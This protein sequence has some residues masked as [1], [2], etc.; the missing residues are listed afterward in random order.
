MRGQLLAQGLSLLLFSSLMLGAC[1]MLVNEMVAREE[2]TIDDGS[3]NE[4]QGVP[5]EGWSIQLRPVK[6]SYQVGENVDFIFGL[7]NN[8]GRVLSV[9]GFGPWV[10]RGLSKVIGP[11]GQKVLY[12]Q[13]ILEWERQEQF[14]LRKTLDDAYK[15]AETELLKLPRELFFTS[16]APLATRFYPH[17]EITFTI[18]LNSHYEFNA[19]GVYT[20]SVWAYELG[21]I[22]DGRQHYIGPATAQVIVVTSR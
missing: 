7:R 18:S 5:A 8:S 22:D 15:Q 20:V 4:P 1:P 14:R 6:K 17:E 3:Q 11:D 21:G 10:P 12:R 16:S 13:G 2:L 9:E 19:P